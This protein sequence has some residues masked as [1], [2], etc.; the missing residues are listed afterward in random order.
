MDSPQFQKAE[1]AGAGGPACQICKQPIGAAY[2]RVNG[3]VAC[4]Q[5]ATRVKGVTPESSHAHLVRGLIYGIGGA[6]VGLILYATF[7]IVT[8]IYIGYIS[9]AVGFIVGKSIKMGSK[10]F[11]GTKYQIMAVLLTYAAVS[12]AAVPIAIAYSAKHRSETPVARSTAPPSATNSNPGAEFGGAQDDASAPSED[13][14]RGAGTKTG[15]ALLAYLAFI[16]LASPFM[17]LAQDPVHGGIGIIIL[18][19]GLRIAWRMTSMSDHAQIVGPFK[20]ESNAAPAAPP[21]SL[22]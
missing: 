9:L 8:G 15:L 22:G 14:P 1:Y 13:A 4:E 5:C 7:T 18:L 6:I 16:G 19:V 17:D 12:M 10:G 21:P 3:A 20:N 11:G 2:Y